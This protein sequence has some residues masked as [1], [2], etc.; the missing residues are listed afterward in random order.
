[1]LLL[2]FLALAMIPALRLVNWKIE[3]LDRALGCTHF[4]LTEKIGLFELKN[5]LISERYALLAIEDKE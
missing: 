5:E 2:A 4:N 3:A 1:M